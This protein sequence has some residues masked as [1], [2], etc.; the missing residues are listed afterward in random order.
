[1][2]QKLI[3]QHLPPNSQGSETI[4]EGRNGVTVR[5]RGQEAPDLNTLFWRWQDHCTHKLVE[6]QTREIISY[7]D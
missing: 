5:A 4:V 2:P 3:N 6:Q 1:M 7:K